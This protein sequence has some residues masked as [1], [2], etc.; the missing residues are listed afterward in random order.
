[1]TI[2]KLLNYVGAGFAVKVILVLFILLF[3]LNIIKKFY[4]REI[5]PKLEKQEQ[6]YRDWEGTPARPGISDRI[7]GVMERLTM[8]ENKVD[9]LDNAI[10]EKVVP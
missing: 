7:P 9:S 10:R 1:M 2:D 3:V 6:C 8:L 5:Q 4:F